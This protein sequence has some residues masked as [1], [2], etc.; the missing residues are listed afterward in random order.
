MSYHDVQRIR[1]SVEALTDRLGNLEKSVAD[2]VES[3]KNRESEE[4][5]KVA[6]LVKGLEASAK[7]SVDAKIES[8][9]SDLKS[10]AK[11]LVPKQSS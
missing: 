3:L 11:N 7:A 2:L 6:E 9:K 5:K 4:T 1:A 8:V 10:Y